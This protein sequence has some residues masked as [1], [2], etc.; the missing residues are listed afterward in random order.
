MKHR[1]GQ[2]LA[3][4]ACLQFFG[5]HWAILQSIAWT[6][7]LITYS[8]QSGLSTGVKQTFDGRHPCAQCRAIVQERA[9]EQ[10]QKTD[11]INFQLTAS[12]EII[13]AS[14]VT[15]ATPSVQIADWP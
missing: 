5:G 2:L 6:R 7:M 15:I 10:T 11:R 13:L 12:P 9:K 8:T 3:L 4:L 14:S 1:A